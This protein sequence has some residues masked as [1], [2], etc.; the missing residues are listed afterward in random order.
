VNSL[1]KTLQEKE[2]ELGEFSKKATSN[3]NTTLMVPSKSIQA[4]KDEVK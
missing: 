2:K 4:K 3:G 1:K